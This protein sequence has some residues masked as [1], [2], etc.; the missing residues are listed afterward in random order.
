MENFQ[1]IRPQTG[2]FL[3]TYTHNTQ[4]DATKCITLLRIC[5]QSK[6]LEITLQPPVYYDGSS[7]NIHKYL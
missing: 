5:T 6:N 1:E 2:S 3:A 7:D 4:I